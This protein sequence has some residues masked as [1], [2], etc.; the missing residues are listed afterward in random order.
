[1]MPSC[2]RLGV[3][4]WLAAVIGLAA[5]T[6]DV[7][8]KVATIR[9]DPATGKLRTVVVTPRVIQPRVI[10]PVT[11][12]EAK[13]PMLLVPDASLNEI[14]AKAAQNY[15]MDP[16]LVHSVIQVESGYNPT[17]V[18]SKGA[19][20]LMQLIPSTARRFGVKDVFNPQE[21]IEAG[22]RYLKYLTDMF[23]GDL[24][25]ALA[26]YNAGEGA[27]AKYNTI[28]PYRET[29]NY[30]YQ[31]GRRFGAARRAQDAKKESAPADAKPAEAASAPKIEQYVDSEGRL[32]L[33]S[34]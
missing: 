30:V 9:A 21:N 6:V 22:V 25:L 34:Q 18:S 4:V 19:Q 23:K 10:A 5:D 24:R 3:A 28:P 17:A 15:Q 1:M 12:T 8:R 27:V 7:P 32:V 14:V 2:L 33:R 31:V 20:G 26:A 13:R 16:L 29:E 11:Q